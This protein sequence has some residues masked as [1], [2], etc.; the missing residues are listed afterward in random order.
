MV[1][2]LLDEIFMSSPFRRSLCSVF[3]R[4]IVTLNYTIASVMVYMNLIVVADLTCNEGL[5]FRHISMVA[6]E[7]L[8][9]DVLIETRK[10]NID[11]YFALL[12]E[13][14]WFDFVDDFVEPEWLIG[15]VRIDTEL[16]SPRTIMVPRIEYDNTLNILGQIKS[17]R[18]V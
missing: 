4:G 2:S 3:L 8:K 7:D 6:R 16:N 18:D 13:K 5:Y 11:Y 15:G 17:L 1:N 10:E 12:R 14:G 9:Y